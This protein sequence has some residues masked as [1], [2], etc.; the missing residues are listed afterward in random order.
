MAALHLTRLSIE[1]AEF[2]AYHGVRHEEQS[3]GGRYQVD[4]DLWYDA[5]R[6]VVSD[7]LSDTVNYEDVLFVVNEHMSGEPYEL[8]ETLAFGIATDVIDRFPLVHQTTVRVRKL[9]VPIQHIMDYVE[10]EVTQMRE[11]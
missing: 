7:T 4:V 8:I 2:F 10:A 9:N 5:A 3:L 6:A 11:E 1:N